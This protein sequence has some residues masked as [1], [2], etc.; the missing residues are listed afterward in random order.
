MSKKCEI[1]GKEIAYP[2]KHNVKYCV[3]CRDEAYRSLR[4]ASNR[5]RSKALFPPIPPKNDDAELN[6]R[7]REFSKQC[8]GCGH[9]RRSAQDGQSD[10]VCHYILDTGESRKKYEK[11]GKCLAYNPQK[12]RGGNYLA[13]IDDEL[14]ELAKYASET[15][16]QA[17]EEILRTQD[18]FI[19]MLKRLLM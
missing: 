17:G 14:A 19:K 2:C 16:M 10:K 3:D 1:C 11:D 6:K 9:W 5:K 4:L 8:V 12:I 18:Q 7:I 15:M 13:L